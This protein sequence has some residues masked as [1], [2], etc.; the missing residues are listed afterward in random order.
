MSMLDISV[1][2]GI[3]TGR[4]GR[5]RSSSRSLLGQWSCLNGVRPL[6]AHPQGWAALSNGGGF[7]PPHEAGP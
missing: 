6:L 2:S 4:E 7:L 1:K 3:R 5:P